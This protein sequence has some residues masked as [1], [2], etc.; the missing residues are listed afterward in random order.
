MKIAL[1][2]DTH[3][4][5]RNDSPIFADYFNRFYSS[6]FFPYLDVAGIKAVIHLGDIVDRRKYINFVTARR[7]REEFIDPCH[8]RGINLHLIIGNHDT[9]YKNTNNVNSI[10]ELYTKTAYNLSYYD[11]PTEVDFDGC[12]ILFM[13][14]ICTDNYDESIRAIDNTSAQIMFGHLEIKGFQMYKGTIIDHGYEPELFGK[15]DVVCSG[16][17]HHKST[18]GNI[19]YLG[20]PYEITW[21]D[22]DDPRGFHVFDTETRELIFVPNPYKMFVKLKYDDVNNTM[23]EILNRPL[24]HLK[25]TYV[26]IVVIN[27]T[28]PYWFDLF[29]E[30][31]EKS[32]VIELQVV[33]DHLNLN[34]ENDAD[35]INEA[36]DT[37][38]I[39]NKYITNLDIKA[40][41]KKLE[42][43]IQSL[44]NEAL[45]VE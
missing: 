8:E 11:S 2:T 16:H 39:L 20:A 18:N 41:K 40:D 25:D 31:V 7:L 44:Y 42:V 43:L 6:V 30:K 28:N 21:S 45:A 19:S 26:K 15:F 4:G 13:P 27:K 37:V 1:I 22:Y 33:E 17:Y 34:L 24:D 14:W 38:T 3:W 32:G 12:P 10:R 23:E 5:A 9:T 35:I 29:V 36:E